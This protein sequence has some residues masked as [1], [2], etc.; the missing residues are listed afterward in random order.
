MQASIV[1][2]MA[3]DLWLVSWDLLQTS[4]RTRH[5]LEPVRAGPL[6]R[7]S[8][9]QR[10]SDTGSCNKLA[11]A[12]DAKEAEDK[13]GLRA[14]SLWTSRKLVGVQD[15]YEL[16]EDASGTLAAGVTRHWRQ[17]AAQ[18]GCGALHGLQV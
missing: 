8:H 17:R 4:Q 18:T 5:L 10:M 12:I 6:I 2:A 1:A 16:L 13:P 9:E 7:Q 14:C 11:T 3:S 15:Q